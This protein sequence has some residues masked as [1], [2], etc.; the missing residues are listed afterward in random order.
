VKAINCVDY[1]HINKWSKRLKEAVDQPKV[2]RQIA[3]EME[4]HAKIYDIKPETKQKLLE[5]AHLPES[6]IVPGGRLSR[7]PSD[8]VNSDDSDS[9]VAS[10]YNV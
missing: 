1:Y 7:R 6:I 3:D 8:Y 9:G 5:A 4:E 10:T 2:V